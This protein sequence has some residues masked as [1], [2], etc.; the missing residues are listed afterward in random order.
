[1]TVI[2]GGAPTG[3]S[4]ASGPMP[5]IEANGL[6]IGYDVS[7][8]GPPLVLL[9]GATSSAG[10]DFRVMMPALLPRFRCYEPDAR[11]HGRT[12]WDTAAGGFEADWLVSDAL[13]FADAM[14]LDM[15]HLIGF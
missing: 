5:T 12:R 15:F 9:H 11:G 14:A 3:E 7:G 13:A 4:L 10:R 6:A 2:V 1:M 8:D